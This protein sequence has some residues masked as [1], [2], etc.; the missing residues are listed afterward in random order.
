[1][2]NEDLYHMSE[3]EFFDVLESQQS[4]QNNNNKS[5]GYVRMHETKNGR[6]IPISSMDDQHLENTVKLFVKI[7]LETKN[8]ALFKAESTINLFEQELN[9][10]KPI[11]VQAAKDI[12]S[13]TMFKLEPYLVEMIIRNNPKLNEVGLQINTVLERKNIM[14][15]QLKENK[16]ELIS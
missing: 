7:M 6:K 14:Y 5:K 1:M 2:E 16:N 12:I 11:S 4:K 13:N 9:G 15:E 8:R 10:F 3:T